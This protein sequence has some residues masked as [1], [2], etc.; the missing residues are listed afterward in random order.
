LELRPFEHGSYSDKTIILAFPYYLAKISRCE[1]REKRLIADIE[2]YDE[3]T[4]LENL[5][6]WYYYR[7]LPS[8]SEWLG[9]QGEKEGR[10]EISPL[11]WRNEVELPLIPGLM[12]STK[13]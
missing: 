12:L 11:K 2:K 4:T 6:C 5:R 7:K 8:S 3:G 13:I 1:I 9:E 10:G